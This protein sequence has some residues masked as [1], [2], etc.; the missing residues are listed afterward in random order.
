[1]PYRRLPKT[2]KTRLYALKKAIE[3]ESLPLDKTPIPPKMIE[4]AKAY[5]P[6]FQTLVTQ[7]QIIYNKRVDANKK[8]TDAVK[9]ARMYVSHFIQ[10]L[11]MTIQR[12]E[13]KKEVKN[14]YGLEPDDFTVPDL[15][16]DNN[17][18]L[19]GK[20]IIDGEKQRIANGGF[21]LTYPTIQKVEMYYEIFAELKVN[22][23]THNESTDRNHKKVKLM[24]QQVDTLILM[25]W[26]AIE[27][28]YA[29]LLP[30]AKYKACR[31]C[32]VIYYY[33]TGEKHL[34]PKTDEY[35]KINEESTLSLDFDEFN[36]EEEDTEM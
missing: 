3:L 10:V 30:Y 29:N 15:S 27:A 36:Q 2:D 22:Q 17:L 35:I 33:R 32:G 26:N 28:Y 20:R 14:L 5:F 9:T 21:P 11:N 13:M 18:E 1:M 6:V 23:T 31:D 4:Q 16:N 8:Y 19:W 7:Y 25:I 34:T 24:R 12:N